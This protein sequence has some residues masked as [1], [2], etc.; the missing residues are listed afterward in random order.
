MMGGFD[1]GMLNIGMLTMVIFW[2]LVISGAIRLVVALVLR[3][4]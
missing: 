4:R 2:V 3:S 1:F